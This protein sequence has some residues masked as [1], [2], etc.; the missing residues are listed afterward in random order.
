MVKNNMKITKKKGFNQ[1][2]HE[3]NFPNQICLVVASVRIKN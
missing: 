2:P 3:M 1:L